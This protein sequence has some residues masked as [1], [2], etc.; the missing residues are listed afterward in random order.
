MVTVLGREA[1]MVKIRSLV[2]CALAAI[3]VGAA[4][5]QEPG[6]V[7]ETAE[8][9]LVEVPV[10]VLDK[11]GAPL[12]GLEAK[13]FTLFDDGRRQEIVGFDAVNLADHTAGPG[14]ESPSASARRR[15]RS[16]SISPSRGPSRSW[17]RGRRRAI[18]C[19]TAL[20]PTWRRSR[21]TRSR[22]A[23]GCW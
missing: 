16:S 18:S 13:D 6:P 12:H 8:V 21:S 23:C 5:A 7:R 22:R 2:L 17:P 4:A 14:V 19:S 11:N 9:S 3:G 1:V 10:R 20:R 15:F